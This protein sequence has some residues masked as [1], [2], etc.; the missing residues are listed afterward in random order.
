[1]DIKNEKSGPQV[2]K[3]SKIGISLAGIGITIVIAIILAVI[4]VPIF[5]QAHAGELNVRLSAVTEFVLDVSDIIRIHLIMVECLAVA[6]L[7]AGLITIHCVK[8]RL[9]NPST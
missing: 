5:K 2:P 1:M 6:F 3:V 4:A 9:D 7:I 8:L